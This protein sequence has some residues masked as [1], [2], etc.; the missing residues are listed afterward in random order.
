ME[1][2]YAK[3]HLDQFRS[4]LMYSRP[5]LVMAPKVNRTV[6]QSPTA[7]VSDARSLQSSRCVIFSLP[8]V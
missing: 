2:V 7:H 6:S 8:E 3:I 5:I 4:K 1:S